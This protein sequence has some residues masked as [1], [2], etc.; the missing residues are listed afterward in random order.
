LK[1]CDLSAG[2][3]R[4][5]L[6]FQRR[7]TQSDGIGGTSLEWNDLFHTKADVRP[8]SGREALMGMQREASVTHRIFIRYREDLLPSDRIIMRTKP[9]Q[10]IAIINVEMRNR[11]LEL[12]CL[13]GVAT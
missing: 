10:I 3:L 5:P 8:L 13:E 9:M 7:Q 6:T 2:A 4:E 11:W 1:C 12:Q